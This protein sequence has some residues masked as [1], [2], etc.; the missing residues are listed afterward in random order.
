MAR[1][2]LDWNNIHLDAL[3]VIS[4]TIDNS[5]YSLHMLVSSN[6]DAVNVIA[7]WPYLTDVPLVL[8]SRF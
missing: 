3:S 1:T 8:V 7:S 5:L 2:Q 4:T 6:Y